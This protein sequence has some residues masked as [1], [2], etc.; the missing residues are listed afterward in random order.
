MKI[1]VTYDFEDEFITPYTPDGQILTTSF[2]RYARTHRTYQ[3]TWAFSYSLPKIMYGSNNS[4]YTPQY[5][6]PL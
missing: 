5:E 4:P 6:T 3:M 1:A 2:E